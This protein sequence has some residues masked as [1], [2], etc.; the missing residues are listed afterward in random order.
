MAELKPEGGV[1]V[2]RMEPVVPG[3]GAVLAVLAPVETPVAA[4]SH[5]DGGCGA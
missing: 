3:K 5:E 2:G 1:G 4:E